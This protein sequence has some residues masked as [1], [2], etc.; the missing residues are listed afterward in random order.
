MHLEFPDRRMRRVS[1]DLAR[2][3]AERD[4]ELA[5]RDVA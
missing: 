4:C 2:R 3:A 5:C 1:G